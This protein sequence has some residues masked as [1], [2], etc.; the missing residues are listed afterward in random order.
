MGKG[1]TLQIK[2][3]PAFILG[4]GGGMFCSR[5]G[6]LE[7]VTDRETLAAR[8][9]ELSKELRQK[10]QFSAA[11]LDD[12]VVLNEN[13]LAKLKAE[14]L[15]ADA[16]LVYLIGPMPLPTV[17][18]WG[19][20][21]IA[22]SGQYTPMLAL[23]AFGVERHSRE[24][25]TIALD[26][27]DIDEQIRVLEARKKLRDARIVLLGFPPSMFF[28]Q[29]H[30]LPDLELAWEKMSIEFISVELRELTAQLPGVSEVE[31]QILAERWRQ[32]AKE[33]VEP[34]KTDIINA[35]RLFLAITNIMQQRKATALA[36]NC[37]EL[38]D[39][40]VPPPCY[41][42]S[43]LRDE[44]VHAACESDVGAL[45]TMMMLGYLADAPAFMGNI[46]SANPESNILMISHC[47]VPTRMAGFSQP[48]Q[49]Y[50]LRNYHGRQGV[51]AYVELDTGREVT[52]AR[53]SRNL[54]KIGLLS[55]ELTDCQDTTTCRTTISVQVADV[56]RFVQGTFGNH[57][58]VV[59]GNYAREL[60]ALSRSL[61][62]SPLEL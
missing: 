16:L 42:L 29:W 13:D 12:T 25:I 32:E 1:T 46:V 5:G 9:T 54:D 47:V 4:M 34:S 21:I 11:L 26:I 18:E 51:T 22:F 36:I 58:A 24:Q 31:A 33:V 48:P 27:S 57:H 6:A 44:G 59:Y 41:A 37:L 23:Y 61:D 62:I 2:V 7:R 38:M 8:V 20:P 45:L 35:A 30:H 60:K 53:L 14:T 3:K 40:K 43:R 10:L 56:R 28:S 19:L 49:C 17:L 50:T 55:G 52:V 15:E 39:L